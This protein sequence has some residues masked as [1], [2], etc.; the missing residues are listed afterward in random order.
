[1]TQVHVMLQHSD[2]KSRDDV[3]ARDDNAGD[4]ISLR[5]ARGAVHRAIKF[6]FTAQFF[7]APPRFGLVD[8]AAVEVSIDRHLLARQR[9]QRESG[10]DFGYANRPVIDNDIL[11]GDQHQENDGSD[12][13]IPADDETPEGFDHVPCRG[14]AS[15]PIE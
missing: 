3:Y 7:P 15:V 14:S 10:R 8:Q 13:V 9:I 2:Q 11:D 5:K 4:R 6:G 1:M 12:D